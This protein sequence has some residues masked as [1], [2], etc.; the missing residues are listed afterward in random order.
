V[1]YL[2]TDGD[3]ELGEVSIEAQIWALKLMGRKNNEVKI[4]EIFARSIQPLGREI[5][6]P[7]LGSL[8][9]KVKNYCIKKDYGKVF[10]N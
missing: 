10:R 4:N 9:V 5:A 2:V 1:G 7:L 6:F 3:L 8:P